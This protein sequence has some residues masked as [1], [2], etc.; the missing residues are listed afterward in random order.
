MLIF[1][2]LIERILLEDYHLVERRFVCPSDLEGY[3]GRSVST[4]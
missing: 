1:N 4:W 2:V 3:A